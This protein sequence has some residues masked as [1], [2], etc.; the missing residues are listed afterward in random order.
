MSFSGHRF[1]FRGSV[2]GPTDHAAALAALLIASGAVLF[3][4][5]ATAQDAPPP[6]VAAQGATV[7]DVKIEG[8]RRVEVDAIRSAITQRKGQPLDPRGV[9]K[10]IRAVMKLGFFSDVVVELQGTPDAPVLV[11]RV[12]ERPTVRETRIEGNDEL[13]KDDLKDTVELKAFS[14][15]DL[16]AVRKDVKKIKEKYAE[17]GYYLAEVTHRIDERPDNQVDVVYV[18]DERAKVQVK[19][20]RFLG[21]AHVADGELLAVMQTRPGGYLSLLSSMGTYREE[22]FQHDLQGVQAVYLDRG[23][24]NVKVGNPSIALSPDKRFLHITIPVEEGEQY[25]IGSI[26]FTGQLLDREP[27]L[28][29]IVRAK[30]GEIFSRSK[31]QQDL[32]AVGDVFRDLGYAYA[33]VTPLTQTDPAARTLDLTYEIQPGP[34]VRF[35]R[36]DIIGNDKTR[37]KVIRRELRIY[38]GELYSGTGLR[39]SR[40]RVNALGFFETV[41]I[42]TKQGSSEDTIVAVV[43]VKERATGTFQ[44]GAGFSSYENFILTGQ[45][46]QN[47]FFGWGQT[48]SLQVQWSSVRQLGQIQFVEPYFLDTKWTFAFDLYATEG[49]YTT[50]TRRAVGGSMTWGYELNGLAPYWSFA[51]HLEDMR[52]FATYTN[53]RVDVSAS[54]LAAQ[55]VQQFKDG[56]TSALRLSLQWDRRDNRLFPTRGFFLSGSAEVAPPLL[57]PESLFGD[58]ILFTR[59]AVDARAYRPIWLGLVGRA[60]L[61]LGYI[62]DWDSQHRVPISEKYYV[63]G[64]NSV[65]GYRYLS[66]SPVEFVPTWQDPS[67]RRGALYV[68]G[69]KQVVLNLELEFPLFKAVG[70]RGVVFSDFGNAFAP[71]EFSDPNV[72]YSLYKSVGFGFRWQSPIGPLRFEWGI[73]LDRRREDP[74]NGG[75]YI[76]QAVDFQFTIGNFF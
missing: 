35:E 3:P 22:A 40:Q 5:L 2:K 42:T 29:R 9:A 49:I 24:V 72:P 68:G 59:Y 52:L 10:D 16:V 31:I 36:I 44:V 53:E 14:I 47:N 73:P 19:E 27:A 33:N 41:D 1:R 34:K 67:A 58:V 65:R 50:F 63:G 62:R 45:I 13:S 60:K 30:Q 17:K 57:A 7:A 11:Y 76:D 25:K 28:R 75:D 51:R 46:S 64:I 20:V 56:T 48:L 21:N 32:F 6:A 23:Y 43:E 38:E 70:V 61:T 12:T 74:V 4:V 69:D 66:I 37:D 39:A 18:I 54:G 55:S 26:A 15:L 71:G 8:N